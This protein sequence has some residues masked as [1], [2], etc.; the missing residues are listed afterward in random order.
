MSIRYVSNEQGRKPF[1]HRRRVILA[2]VAFP[3]ENH[4]AGQVP[5]EQRLSAPQTG[6]ARACMLT[7]TATGAPTALTKPGLPAHGRLTAREREVLGLIAQGLT[8][9]Q[10]ARELVISAHTVNAHVRSIFTKLEVNSRSAATRSALEQ[11]MV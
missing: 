6:R 2:R 4:L 10:I 3:Q 11:Q 5:F 8:N 1:L 7:Q 9:A